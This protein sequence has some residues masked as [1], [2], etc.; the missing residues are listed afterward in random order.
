MSETHC[1]LCYTELETREV[2]PCYDCGHDPDELRQ[3]ADGEH[4][5]DEVTVL[6][7]KAVLCD[8]CQVD[9]SSYAPTYF[10]RPLGRPVGGDMQL[11]R[12]VQDPRPAIDKFC[13]VCQ[14]RLAFLRFVVE[15]RAVA[16]A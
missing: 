13:P 10:G 9:F 14:R 4:T 1:P 16:A 5:Y 12:G 7:V 15:A 8:F 11:V 2:A 6:G 3:L